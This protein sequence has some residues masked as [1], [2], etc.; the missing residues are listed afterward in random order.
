MPDSVTMTYG[1]YTLSPVP[2]VSI[3]RRNTQVGNREYPVAFTFEM[4]LN[5]TLTPLPVDQN[6][7]LI[8]LDILMEELRQ[9]F[10]RDGKLLKIMCGATTIMEIYPRIKEIAF[11]ESNNNWVET[12]PYSITIEYDDDG[13]SEDG[14][15]NIPPYIEEYS[16]EWQMEWIQ[17][18]RYY[19]WDL[20]T[21]DNQDDDAY[22]GDDSNNTFECR[23][24]HSISVKGKQ[25]WAGTGLTGVA[26]NSV[27]NALTWLNT[28]YSGYGYQP[29]TLG[30]SLSGWNNLP[31]GSGY[32]A[33]DHFR[34]H[35]IN[36]TDGTIS[37]VETWY[38]VGDNVSMTGASSR[39]F[40]EDFTI[41]VREGTEVGLT[42][43][44]IEGELRGLADLDYGNIVDS[45]EPPMIRA[46]STAYDNAKNA[47][48]EMQSRLFSRAQY[49]Y[50]QDHSRRLNPRPLNKVTGHNPSKGVITYSYEYNDRPCSFITNSLSENFTIVDKHPADVFSVLPVIGRSAG[51]ILQEINT[52]T[53]ATREVN[54]ELIMPSPTG[55]TLASLNEYKPTADVTTLL[56]QFETELTGSYTQ[57]FKSDDTE[58]WS[59]ITGRYSRTVSWTFQSCSGDIDTSFCE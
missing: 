8:K 2:L 40:T 25:S 36:D 18:H 54:I 49:V 24:T 39:K 3:T 35:S 27:D 56:C 43:I 47:W 45:F 38:I 59:P 37:L 46:N 53:E 34:T 16:D 15:G 42:N 23:V 6:P 48:Q 10:N 22:Y 30:H 14:S 11:N 28:V 29:S 31:F 21:L 20:S 57:V 19:E 9:A 4:T 51:P 44:S 26:T 52:V 5:G 50:Q 41:N 7:N 17:E 32:G 1:D 33:Y 58:S 12:I 55:C 13:Y